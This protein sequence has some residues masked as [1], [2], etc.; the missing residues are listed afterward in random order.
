[1]VQYLQNEDAMS[2]TISHKALK[3][4]GPFLAG[5]K[6]DVGVNLRGLADECMLQMCKQLSKDWPSAF[7]QVLEF[8]ILRYQ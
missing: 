2:E 5:G 8:E 1:M 3:T 7:L 4:S 6:F